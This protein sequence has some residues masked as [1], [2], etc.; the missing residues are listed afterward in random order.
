MNT[1]KGL[2]IG[3]L[4]IGSFNVSAL[5][6]QQDDKL[7]LT[8]GIGINEVL[9][10]LGKTFRSTIAFNSGFEKA[11]KKNWYGQ[12]ELNFNSLRYDQQ[13][14]D[15]TSPY[16]FQNTNSSLFMIGVNWGRDFRFKSSPWFTSAYLGTGYLNIGKPRVN[17]DEINKII[18]QSVVRRSG[19]IGRA[20]ARVG[21]KTN[22]ALFQTI[23]FDGSWLTSSF[24]ADGTVFRSL[25]FF[26]GMR[27]AVSSD[28]KTAKSQM[29]AIRRLK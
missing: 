12:V 17:L 15:E 25:S 18:T 26:A 3:L 24:K 11:F 29:K 16:L 21:V 8:T 7:H 22:S 14:K 28:S 10:D 20:G 6:A 1:A 2:K 19:I 13:V 5:N 9:G 4:V 27:M 23:Y